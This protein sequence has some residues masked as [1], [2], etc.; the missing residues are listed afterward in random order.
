[1]I[2]GLYIISC[3][4]A[5]CLLFGKFTTIDGME[6]GMDVFKQKVT[7]LKLFLCFV[8]LWNTIVLA[9]VLLILFIYF[10]MFIVE[11]MDTQIFKDK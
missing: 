11:Q 9:T 7:Y 4:G 5:F 8:P 1:M 2:I 6:I 10:I 3:I